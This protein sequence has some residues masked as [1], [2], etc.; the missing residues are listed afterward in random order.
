MERFHVTF[1]GLGL[2]FDISR[3]AFQL[4]SFKVY[5]Y[6]LII[7]TGM[8]LAVIYAWRS[9]KRYKVD[10]NKLF[11]CILAGLVCG[12]AGAR[13]YFCLFKWDY[14]GSHPVEI[15]YINNG[16]LAIYGGIIG[17]VGGGL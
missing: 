15:L 11:N 3:V 1:P 9:A 2:E 16:G 17:A 12:V 13:L 10:F 6:G 8:I 7:M 5:W 14:Y 4:G